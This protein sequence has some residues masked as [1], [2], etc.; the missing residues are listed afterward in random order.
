MT[1]ARPYV[2]LL[3]AALLAAGC[4]SGGAADP[5]AAERSPAATQPET[6]PDES[7]TVQVTETPTESTV[8]YDPF[9]TTIDPNR[10]VGHM[11]LASTRSGPF[12][13]TDELAWLR[14]TQWNETLE[15][16]EQPPIDIYQTT[17]EGQGRHE[18]L[19]FENEDDWWAHLEGASWGLFANAGGLDLTDDGSIEQVS[20]QW[21]AWVHRMPDREH[22]DQWA[23]WHAT[24]D[25]VSD[26]QEVT[27]RDVSAPGPRVEMVRSL[28]AEREP[29]G[30]DDVSPTWGAIH[31]A[32]ALGPWV[33][34]VSA[35]GHSQAEVASAADE[36]LQ[37]VTDAIVMA[38]NDAAD[39]QHGS[40]PG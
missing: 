23:D 19:G 10:L 29:D 8:S 24:N 32:V 21:E 31:D 2:F 9:T 28:V 36:L 18:Q 4:S 40:G 3:A 39:E 12:E 13:E 5:A 34:T 7:P 1:R 6:A 17:F 26:A 14:D 25:D 16:P 37:D 15:N 38:H 35:W 27:E 30:P 22:T 20:V 11:R 33:V